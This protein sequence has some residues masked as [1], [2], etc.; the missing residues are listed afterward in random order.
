MGTAEHRE[1]GPSD[2][3]KSK[4]IT[5]SVSFRVSDL[6]LSSKK[7]GHIRRFLVA[8]ASSLFDFIPEDSSGY[9]SE[10]LKSPCPDNA[11]HLSQFLNAYFYLN[12]SW[13]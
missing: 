11:T 13:L 8:L 4:R 7:T 10:L 12:K 1:W 3:I 9:S 5:S 2:G 6:K